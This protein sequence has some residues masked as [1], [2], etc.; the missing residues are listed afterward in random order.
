MRIV[1][2][3]KS[4][5]YKK[6]QALK[7]MSEDNTFV[8]DAC[9]RMLDKAH[10]KVSDVST[11]ENVIDAQYINS[12]LGANIWRAPE[13]QKIIFTKVKEY[14]AEAIVREGVKI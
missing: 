8:V 4:N 11:D 2:I 1:T 13:D 7:D 10:V 6:I 9:T 3:D 14:L 12:W 5:L